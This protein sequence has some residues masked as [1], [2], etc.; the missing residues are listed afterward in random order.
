MI[1]DFF[2]SHLMVEVIYLSE[3]LDQPAF[4]PTDQ[5]IVTQVGLMQ[6]YNEPMPGLLYE[7][8]LP[9]HAQHHHRRQP[10]ASAQ[11]GACCG[12]RLDPRTGMGD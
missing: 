5:P 7:A 10:L 8:E 1:C 3:N 11:T 4:R 12:V 6:E 2:L 9:A